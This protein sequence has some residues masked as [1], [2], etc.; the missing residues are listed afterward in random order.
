[1]VIEDATASVWRGRA[2]RGTTSVD[3]RTDLWRLIAHAHVC[4]DLA[5]GP[6][7]AKECVESLRFGTPII[8]P[9]D[10]P[11]AVAH[12]GAGGGLVYGNMADLLL[13]VSRCESESVRARLSG[14][15]REYADATYGDSNLFCDRVYRALWD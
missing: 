3:S 10:A 8:V 15:G 2:L 12:A 14:D 1:V 6:L 13:Q 7:V 5:P 4:I 11:A 9:E